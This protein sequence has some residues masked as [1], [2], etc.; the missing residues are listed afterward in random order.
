MAPGTPR[1]LAAPGRIGERPPPHPRLPPFPVTSR[2]SQKLKA[3]LPTPETI[4]GNR[5]LRWL[6]PF[7]AHPRLWHLSRKGVA[8]GVA[9]GV[10]FG[11][12]IPIA[13]MPVAA[14]LA[15][16]LRANLPVAMAS[17]FVTNPVTF[18]PVY[19]VA[20]RLGKAVLGE[21]KAAQP[22]A[23]SEERLVEELTVTPD[24]VAE[25]LGLVDRFKRWLAQIGQVGK[26][27]FVGLAILAVACGLLA[28]A[29]AHA[30]WRLRVR[31]DRRRRLKQ[32]G[33]AGQRPTGGK[34]GG[35]GGN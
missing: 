23:M 24:P 8:L 12:L 22:P 13:Q 33:P 30:A 1:E 10:F 21:D 26:P 11:L 15:V 25:R 18:G 9:L 20:Y 28:Y 4:L 17:T 35:A 5:W 19:Y 34:G 2:F 31:W 29:I 14:T 3:W 27:L 6:A 7:M 16:V 32:R